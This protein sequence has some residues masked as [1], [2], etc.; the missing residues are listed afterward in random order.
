[1]SV[2]AFSVFMLTGLVGIPLAHALIVGSLVA[3]ERYDVG[4]TSIVLEQMVTQASSFPLRSRTSTAGS[5]VAEIPS[6]NVM[7]S[8]NSR[9]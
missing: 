5:A 7:P 9:Q 3:L 2:L 8:S 4:S 1:M 6:L